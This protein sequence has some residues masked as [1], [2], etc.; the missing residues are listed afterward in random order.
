MNFNK[1][2]DPRATL[3]F[4]AALLAAMALPSAIAFG[5]DIRELHGVNVWD[6]PLKFQCSLGLHLMTLAFAVQLL[7]A[8]RDRPAVRGAALLVAMCALLE[9]LY[10]SLQAARGRES[11]F[12]RATEWEALAYYGG[13]G[14]G[15]LLILAGTAAVGWFLWRSARARTASGLQ[16]GMALGLLA[17]SLA[18][19]IAVVPLSSGMVGGL[20]HWV[21]GMRTDANGLWLTGWSTT[22]G[23]LR[24][25]H[26]FATHLMQVAPA[27]GWLADRVDP[28]HTRR[29]VQIAVALGLVAVIATL[30]QAVAGRPLVG[31]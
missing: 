16:Y 7:A 8:E 14:T 15:A 21:G 29:W 12:N 13:M 27:S 6:K 30:A 4:A 9:A 26:F 17:G 10:I 31:A 3:W 24:V 1:P 18:T 23:D 2:L 11:H 19:F 20:G 22:G 5:S 25:P 28:A